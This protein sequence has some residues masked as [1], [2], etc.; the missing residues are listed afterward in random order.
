MTLGIPL[1]DKVFNIHTEKAVRTIT[2]E[3]MRL[4]T[5]SFA[6]KEIFGENHSPF[7]NREN[8]KGL[9]E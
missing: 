8:D 7:I 3:P 1:N 6:A 5:V 4:S 9:R 2:A